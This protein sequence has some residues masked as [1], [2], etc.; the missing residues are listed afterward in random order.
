MH[1]WRLIM[2]HTIFYRVSGCL[3]AASNPTSVG[4]NKEAELPSLLRLAYGCL[5]TV[6]S[7]IRTASR[8]LA[9]LSTAPWA[10]AALS[11]ESWSKTVVA[12]ARAQLAGNYQPARAAELEALAIAA[13]EALTVA[14][15]ER[16]IDAALE[17]SSTAA[18]AAEN[19]AAWAA[20]L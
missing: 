17:A 6:N 3:N 16:D 20:A 4:L 10:T 19:N 12:R 14:E 8:D 2:R 1:N 13:H 9:M 15:L 7:A 18:A 11:A 5:A